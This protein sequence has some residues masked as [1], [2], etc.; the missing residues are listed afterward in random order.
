MF[1]HALVRCDAGLLAVCVRSGF[2]PVRMRLGPSPALATAPLA[3]AIPPVRRARVRKTSQPIVACVF[4]GSL[5]NRENL[6]Y[7]AYKGG[8]T[9]PSAVSPF[10]AKP[11]FATWRTRTPALAR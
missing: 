8:G 11:L 3:L 1:F 6:A 2:V 5:S 4:V 10:S 9:C 7:Y